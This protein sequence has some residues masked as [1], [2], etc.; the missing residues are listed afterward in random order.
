MIVAVR[1]RP[2]GKDALQELALLGV[3]AQTAVGDAKIEQREGHSRVVAA[4]RPLE[5]RK[6][7]LQDVSLLR[8]VA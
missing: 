3:V 2:Y 4:V 8:I 7:A 5:D 6:R 1:A